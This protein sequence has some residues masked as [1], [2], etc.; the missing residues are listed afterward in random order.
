MAR[1]GKKHT[2]GS[3]MYNNLFRDNVC[4]RGWQDCYI[5]DSIRG[6]LDFKTAT[7]CVSMLQYKPGSKIYPDEFPTNSDLEKEK[8]KRPVIHTVEIR[9]LSKENADIA[10]ATEKSN[11]IIVVRGR[12]LP[13]GDQMVQSLISLPDATPHLRPKAIPT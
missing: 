9:G 3:T 10:S 5:Q 1:E 7:L 11:V 12:D 13:K 2:A 6:N 4:Q 8:K